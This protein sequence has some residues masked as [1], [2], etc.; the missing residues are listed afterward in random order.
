MTNPVMLTGVGLASVAT[1]ETTGKTITDHAISQVKDK[2]CRVFR[3]LRNEEIC[4]DKVSTLVPI[5][6][7]STLSSTVTEIESR[8]R[9]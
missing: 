9:P 5:A 4:Q 6:T 2:D 3:A 8:Y 7:N 1:N